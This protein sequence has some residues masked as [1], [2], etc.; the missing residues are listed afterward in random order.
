V[1]ADVSG[2][3]LEKSVI[4]VSV[5]SVFTCRLL[6]VSNISFFYVSRIA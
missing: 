2:N 3:F 4:N 5:T 6:H 1:R